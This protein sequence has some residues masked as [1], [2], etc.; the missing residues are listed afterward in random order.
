[1][2]FIVTFEVMP[3]ESTLF[4][5]TIFEMSCNVIKLTVLT[6]VSS[7]KNLVIALMHSLA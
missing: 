1:M 6:I 7:T 3:I 4:K 2:I 5:F